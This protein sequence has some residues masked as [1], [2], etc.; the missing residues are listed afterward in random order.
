M[1]LLKR[2]HIYINNQSFFSHLFLTA[3][4]ACSFQ[5]MGDNFWACWTLQ[6]SLFLGNL[7]YR[8]PKMLGF[9]WV[10]LL[11]LIILRCEVGVPP[12]KETPISISITTCFSKRSSIFMH[13]SK[14]IQ[15]QKWAFWLCLSNFGGF[16]LLFFLVKVLG[17]GLKPTVSDSVEFGWCSASESLDIWHPLPGCKRPVIM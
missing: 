6:S 8:F 10:F 15:H 4:F 3:I 16:F 12:F 9:P 1:L 7:I 13:Q 5:G 11:K 17:Y 14:R 2:K